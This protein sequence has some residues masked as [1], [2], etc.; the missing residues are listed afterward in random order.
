MKRAKTDWCNRLQP[1]TVSQLMMI[2]LN[3]PDLD[4]FDAQ[5]AISRWLNAG[6]RCHRPPSLPYGPRQ[7]RAQSESEIDSSDSETE[8]DSDPLSLEKFAADYGVSKREMSRIANKGL[9]V[10]LILF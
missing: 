8:L 10:P 4:S 9:A 1:H 5:P 6:P 2:K 7:A 3:G